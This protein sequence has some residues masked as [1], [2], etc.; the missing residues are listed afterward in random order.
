VALAVHEQPQEMAPLAAH[1]VVGSIVA[2]ERA[3][4]LAVE[5]RG[6]DGDVRSKHP[7]V[8]DKRAALDVMLRGVCDLG[9]EV[10]WLDGKPV[11]GK[12]VRMLVARYTKHD[13]AGDVATI[14]APFRALKDPRSGA[15]IDDSGYDDY[16]RARLR[17][18]IASESMTSP[19][20][21]LWLHDYGHALFTSDTAACHA[22][23]DELRAAAPT[24]QAEWL[25]VPCGEKR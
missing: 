3:A 11:E 20:W 12:P 25:N 18:A 10:Y 9:G 22:K 21:R 23:L 13:E 7:P 19:K 16:Q 6:A 4:G 1:V 17:A 14:C 2:T 15:P 5:V 8:G 24:C